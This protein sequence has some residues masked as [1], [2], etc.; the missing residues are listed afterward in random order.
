MIAKAWRI[1]LNHIKR[2][3]KAITSNHQQ[4]PIL[5]LEQFGALGKLQTLEHHGNSYIQQ[6]N[7]QLQA[8]V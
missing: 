4:S 5:E 3:F 7:V 6:Y 2:V 1:N 8:F